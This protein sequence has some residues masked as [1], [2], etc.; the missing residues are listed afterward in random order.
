MNRVNIRLRVN[1]FQL[2]AFIYSIN[3]FQNPS[4]LSHFQDCICQ[5]LFSSMYTMHVMGI[6]LIWEDVFV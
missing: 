3:P 6:Q 2:T 5:C 4:H 1:I